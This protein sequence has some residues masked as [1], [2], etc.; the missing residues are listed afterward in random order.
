M[1]VCYF[2]C[3]YMFFSFN[4]FMC[5]TYLKL[6]QKIIFTFSDLSQ[7]QEIDDLDEDEVS[8]I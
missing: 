6:L 7:L 2:I 5:V 8:F 1:Y 4:F 3:I